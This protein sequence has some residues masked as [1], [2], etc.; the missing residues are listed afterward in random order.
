MVFKL[1]VILVDLYFYIQNSVILVI[2]EHSSFITEL[3]LMFCI[4]VT[5]CIVD[6]ILGISNYSELQEN[7]PEFLVL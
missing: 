3:N 6:M 2:C 1:V 4:I 5:K 7:S